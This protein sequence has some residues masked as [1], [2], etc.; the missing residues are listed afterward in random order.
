M[1][2]AL[3]LRFSTQM[4]LDMERITRELSDLQ[5]QISSGHKAKDLLGYGP[6][7]SRL[8]STQG[9]LHVTEARA[10][11]VNQL[12]ARFSV[13]ANALSHVAE[14]GSELSLAIR[15]ALSA[16]DG[17]TLDID[18][19]L[20]FATIVGAMNETWNGQPLFAGERMSGAPIRVSTL[21]QLAA[22][23]SPDELF[24]EAERH[25]IIDLGSGTPI[26]LADKASEI[27]TPLFNLMQSFKA[28]LDSAGGRLGEDFT[29][30]QKSQL[31]N[32]ASELD[33]AVAQVTSAEARTGQLQARIESEYQRLK[34]RSNLLNKE[35]GE[36]TAADIPLI[37]IQ[38]STLQAQYEATAKVFSDLSRLSLLD[39]L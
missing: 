25:Q 16:D 31:E 34:A 1:T 2:S 17:R 21:E 7:S 6:E 15:N 5:A 24:D 30:A 20:A 39:Y 27:V 35:I 22:A 12:T 4:Q 18:L 10:S 9:L 8:V 38:L 11:A 37:S 13:Q 29:P 19:N 14:A 36:Q 23:T 32:M 28:M 3:T 33:A 26:R